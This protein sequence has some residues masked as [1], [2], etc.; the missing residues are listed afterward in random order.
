MDA[1]FRWVEGQHDAMR[2][3]VEEWAAINSGSLNAPGIT[4]VARAVAASSLFQ[5]LGGQAEWC[6]LPAFESIDDR[7]EATC[8]APAPALVLRKRPGAKRRVLLAIHLDTVFAPDDPFQ[9][10]T[11]L[12][13]RT[14]GG[15]GVADA[16]GGVVLLLTALAALERSAADAGL[17]WT[18]VLNPDEEIGSPCSAALLGRLAGE[19]DFGLVFEPSLPDGS[20]IRKRKGSGNFTLVVRGKAAH[21]GRAF[22]EGRHAIHALSDM[23]ERVA[24]F[25]DMGVIANTGFVAGGGA[26][27]VVPEFALA[28]VNLRVDDGAQ[29]KEVEERLTACAAEIEARRGVSIMIHGGFQSP[30]KLQDEAMEMLMREV[31]TAGSEVGV[32][33]GWKTSGGVCD[34]NKLA[35]AGLP[36]VDT[37]G[38]QGGHI[39]SAREYLLLDSLVPRTQL[40]AAILGR[41]AAG[42]FIPDFGAR[43]QR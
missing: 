33:V 21:V 13:D 40:C 35:A 6:E 12:D 5:S 16:K 23:I 34:G 37:L 15:P 1:A 4:E 28:R 22:A 7:G 36:N 19:A 8:F 32:D 2:S 24:R 42:I 41:T 14:L 3:W 27:N 20:L 26:V 43:K 30:P 11:E 38:P 18:V 39:H 10:V 29:Q 31:E 25:N 17:G 9:H